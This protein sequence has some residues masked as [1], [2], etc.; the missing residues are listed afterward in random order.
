MEDNTVMEF[1]SLDAQVQT[2]AKFGGTNSEGSAKRNERLIAFY[3]LVTSMLFLNVGKFLSQVRSGKRLADWVYEGRSITLKSVSIGG[4]LFPLPEGYVISLDTCTT[5]W[6]CMVCHSAHGTNI[7][8]SKGSDPNGLA[9]NEW[10]YNPATRELFTISKT[11]WKQYVENRAKGK[12]GKYLSEGSGSYLGKGN[13]YENRFRNLS[14]VKP[15]DLQAAMDLYQAS[16][17]QTPASDAPQTPVT[18]AVVP[19]VE[20]PAVPSPVANRRKGQ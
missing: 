13:H 20:T 7:A 15:S 8:P 9:E 10:Y 11:C 1:E 4:K 6:G 5:V 14:A 3:Q 18:P 12:D 17:V 2:K 19:T 16:E